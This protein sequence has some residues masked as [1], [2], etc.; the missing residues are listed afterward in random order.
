M[1]QIFLLLSILSAAHNTYA[2]IIQ[3]D[4]AR[5]DQIGYNDWD[6]KTDGEYLVIQN[7]IQPHSI[8]FDVGANIGLWSCQALK[9]HPSVQLYSFEPAPK[10]FA[11][12]TSNLRNT[13]NAYLHNIAFSKQKGEMILFF[14]QNNQI[15]TELSG[16]YHRPIVDRI[17]KENPEKI[18]ITTD[19]LSAF[20]QQ[21]DI[22]HVDFLKIDTE[23]S[24]ADI[25]EGAKDLLQNQSIHTIQFEYGGCYLDAHKTLY[26]V[27]TLL[28]SYKY[29]V[30]RIAP[31][32]LIEI[33]SWRPELENFMLS[34][35]LA[36]VHP[37]NLSAAQ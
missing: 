29:T 22:G 20:C 31:W 37:Y 19:T 30:Y 8:V 10:T 35:Y 15:A 34:N 1:Y 3:K 11:K 4:S 5:F 17:T 33:T 32:G 23:G 21:N 14:Y 25:I 13:K 9:L 12:L 27:Y 7:C 26:E 16:L 18:T 6:I 28:T 24:E 2:F 36:T